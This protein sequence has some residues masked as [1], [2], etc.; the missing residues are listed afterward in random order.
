MRETQPF[1][2]QTDQ[3]FII[4]TGGVMSGIGKGLVTSSLG[5]NL[6]VRGLQV[7]PIKIDPYCN[8][9]AGT[10]NPFQHGEVYVTDDGGEID[11]D[12]G[13]YERIL[14]INLPKKNNITTGQVYW[15]V[16][17]RE[18][19]GDY[20]GETVQ[21]IP[22]ITDEIKRRIRS[23][24]VIESSMDRG[25]SIPNKLSPDIVLVEIGGTVGDIEGLPFFEAVRQMQAEVN[26]EDILHVHVT[27]VPF[28]T[29]VGQLKTKPTQHSVSELRKIG[30]SPDLIVC[31]SEGALDDEARRKI[32]LFC[33]VPSSGVFSLPD[34]AN[35]YN[36]PFLLDQQGLGDYLTSHLA[37]DTPS[38]DWTEWKN[39][40]MR[41]D[42]PKETIRIAMP[43]KYTELVDCYI[44][45][46]EALKHAGAALNPNARVEIDWIA[47]EEFEEDSSLVKILD[48]FHGILVPGGF[49]GRG[50][51]GKILAIQRAREC[52]IPFLGICYG[53]QLAV[54]EY[55]RHVLHLENANSTEL[56]ATTPHPV[57][58]LLPD[59][60]DDIDLGGTMRLGGW[61]VEVK[62][63][64]RAFD[65]YGTTS[66]VK[67]HR[68]RY[69]VNPEYIKLLEHE[70]I[71]FSGIAEK[72]M[73]IMELPNHPFFFGTQFHPEFQSRPDR[74]EP[75]YYGFVKSAAER[76]SQLLQKESLKVEGET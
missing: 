23:V 22:H 63:N 34:L 26:R 51:E 27:F 40:V 25:S 6:Q 55:A 42:D 2:M 73:E 64:T 33:G 71:V 20:L 75:V 56:D 52:G 8:L 29:T 41:F 7:V 19:A 9:D 62:E 35:I 31:R 15:D 18:R 65:M 74:P 54:V 72:R 10:M 3:K 38:V 12:F 1:D 59:Q 28:L 67:R 36:A 45:V 17:Q 66:I 13:N 48:Q 49:G 14:G 37:L 44:S 76:K 46:N 43:G 50:G 47:T 60:K 39:L 53:F 70:G 4:I 69:E 30:L 11:Q 68:H 24:G 21:I 57:I 32:A 16:I 58:D 5:K 61:N